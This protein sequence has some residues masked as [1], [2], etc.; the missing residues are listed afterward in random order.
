[1]HATTYLFSHALLAY[2]GLYADVRCE[3]G[4]AEGMQKTKACFCQNDV[5][6]TY[7]ILAKESYAIIVWDSWGTLLI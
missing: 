7:A 3:C 1:M 4:C 5:Q 2:I 6:A